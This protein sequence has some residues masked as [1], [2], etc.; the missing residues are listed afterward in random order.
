MS[1]SIRNDGILLPI[2]T[3]VKVHGL[4]SDDDLERFNGGHGVIVGHD[5]DDSS[6]AVVKYLVL[7][8]VKFYEPQGDSTKVELLQPN[9]KHSFLADNLTVDPDQ[10]KAQNGFFQQC[11][12]EHVEWCVQDELPLDGCLFLLEQ[13]YQACPSAIM[14]TMPYANML[15][16]GGEHQKAYEVIHGF[17]MEAGENIPQKTDDSYPSFCYDV[18]VVNCRA[19]KELAQALEYAL[20]IPM[21]NPMAKD[22]LNTLVDTCQ[23]ILDHQEEEADFPEPVSEILA[24]ADEV[25]RERFPPA[26]FVTIVGR[27]F[28]F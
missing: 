24:R 27:G 13:F 4:P 10:P 5:G 25:R 21:E 20:E 14:I 28:G 9:T 7:L 2:G 22:A 23:K 3:F 12:L 16:K 15:R 6:D 19:Q 8:Y 26:P 17:I 18:C 11:L 1:A